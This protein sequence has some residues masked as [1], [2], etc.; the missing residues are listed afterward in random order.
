MPG[1]PATHGDLG[2]AVTAQDSLQDRYAVRRAACAATLLVTAVALAGCQ[3]GRPA[4]AASG[5][6]GAST[7][8]AATD[9]P[10]SAAQAAAA[11]LT[12]LGPGHDSR[13]D[14]STACS[15]LSMNDV[16]ATAGTTDD[17]A[18][19]PSPWPGAYAYFAPRDE[20]NTVLNAEQVLGSA[21]A[22]RDAAKV[23]AGRDEQWVCYTR[24]PAGILGYYVARATTKPL[25][26]FLGQFAGGQLGH[27]ADDNGAVSNVSGIGDEAQ[28]HRY[29]GDVSGFTLWLGVRQGSVAV[30]VGSHGLP[31]GIYDSS[32]P[33]Q[34][35]KK[36][37][38]KL[39]ALA[40]R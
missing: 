9:R 7:S 24:V 5:R 32:D 3:H 1:G 27:L 23:P 31:S 28:L 6:P 2:D 14:P 36:L 17:A 37:A 40:S 4:T 11:H 13:N 30:A 34:P 8:P 18:D 35:L 19:A 26:T 38:S 29:A 15:L 25:A 20:R 33:L 21:A 39:L 12:A 10:A 16:A 22:K